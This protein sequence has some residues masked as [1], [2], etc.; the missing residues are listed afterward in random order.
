MTFDEFNRA[1]EFI[2]E[3][4]ARLSV[5]LDRDHEWA[6]A[7]IQQLAVSNQRVV[8]L[9]ESN[10]RRLDQN[11]I[12]HRDFTQSQR[13]FQQGTQKHHEEIMSHLRQILGFIGL[14]DVMFFHAENQARE[15]A[16]ASLAA[17]VERIGGIVVDRNQQVVTL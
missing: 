1:M 4:Q 7:M 8:E 10:I 12:E 16:G 3:Q 13:Q 6:K 9:T 2:I 11:D 17:A 5:T 14:T 15:Q